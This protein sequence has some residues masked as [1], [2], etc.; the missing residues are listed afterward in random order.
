MGIPL[1][2]LEGGQLQVLWSEEDMARFP[3]DNAGAELLGR[4]L[5]DKGHKV[6][7]YSA[8]IDMNGTLDFRSLIENAY[9]SA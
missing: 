5:K 2:G 4:A 3:A 7:T 8:T 9:D 1:V 6:W